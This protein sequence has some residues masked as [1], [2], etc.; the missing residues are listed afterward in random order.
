[1][2][3]GFFQDNLTSGAD[4]LEEQARDAADRAQAQADRA[5]N[6]ADR[7]TTKASLSTEQA[8][9]ATEQAALA[10]SDR[11]A[12]QAARDLAEQHR[13]NALIHRQ[14]AETAQG[15]AENARDTALSHRNDAQTAQGAAEGAR[16][17]AITAR[18][19]AEAAQEATQ[20]LLDAFGDQYLGSHATAPTLDDD[21]SALDT[22]DI[23]WDSTNNLLKF[24]DG[25]AWVSPETIASNY[26]TAAGD[27]AAA[28][29]DSENNAAAT[30]A[31]SLKIA[32]NL[33]DLDDVPTARTNLGLGDIAT[34]SIAAY[35]TAAQGT[36]AD[37][38][39]GW[40]DH[41]LVGYDTI[42]S[43]NTKDGVIDARITSEVATLNSTITSN[44]STL[45][46][47][48]DTEVSTLNSTIST[49]TANAANWDTAYGWGNHAVAGYVVASN[50]LSDVDAASARANINVDEAG[51]ALALSIAL[52]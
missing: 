37:T 36:N 50:N 18:Q 52:G 23:Y 16:D 32:Q 24:Y 29:L 39:Y 43:V 41:A 2:A 17:D 42:T 28:A 3:G 44:V 35:A 7:S 12:A 26:A 51:T 13:D 33:A 34:T 49:A 31:S 48:I 10:D 21:G 5:E 11:I 25:S 47:R 1:M 22:G 38:A 6:E 19:G 46:G 40:G 45:N 9:L 20:T 14:G 8:A 27:S 4:L 30:L 15:L